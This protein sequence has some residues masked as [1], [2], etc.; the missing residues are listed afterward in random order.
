MRARFRLKFSNIKAVAINTSSANT[1]FRPL[2]GTKKKE[3][4]KNES[5]DLD[6]RARMTFAATADID[7][8]NTARVSE[9][10]NLTSEQI[11]DYIADVLEETKSI[12]NNPNNAKQK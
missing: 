4:E 5:I 3:K 7:E 10:Q 12:K 11:K 8:S 9:E 1:K 2:D 6:A